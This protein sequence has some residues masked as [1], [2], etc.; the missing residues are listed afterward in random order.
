VAMRGFGHVAALAV[1][2]D[3]VICLRYS[4]MAAVAAAR[5]LAGAGARRVGVVFSMSSEEV[6]RPSSAVRMRGSL[7]PT[8]V[9]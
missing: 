9:A 7:L 3:A 8:P 5:G 6:A 2:G 4:A 1:G